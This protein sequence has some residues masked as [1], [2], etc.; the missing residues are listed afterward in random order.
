[1]SITIIKEANIIRLL[2]SSAP[3]P[4]GTRLTLYTEEE[5][6]SM[7]TAPTAWEAAQI[8]SAFH[9]DEEDWGSSLDHLVV[10]N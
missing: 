5:V 9:E 8:D 6:P 2:A 3:I 7:R 1:M 10:H 4:D